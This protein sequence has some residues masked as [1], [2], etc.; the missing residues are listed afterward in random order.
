MSRMRDRQIT[1]CSCA[2]CSLKKSFPGAKMS[3]SPVSAVRPP[4]ELGAGVGRLLKLGMIEP[5]CVRATPPKS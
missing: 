4:G 2:P 3:V 1:L 5:D